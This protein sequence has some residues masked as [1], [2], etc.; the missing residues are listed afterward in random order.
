MYFAGT[1]VPAAGE[2]GAIKVTSPL[3]GY[4][5]HRYGNTASPATAERQR[6]E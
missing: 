3:D 1:R 6:P 4:G 2:L 5:T